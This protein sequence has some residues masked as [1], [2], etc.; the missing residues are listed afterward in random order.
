[1]AAKKDTK[2]T[3]TKKSTGGKKG[4]GILD[5][6][7]DVAGELL[8]SA[9]QGAA[10]TGLNIAAEAVSDMLEGGDAGTKGTSSAGKATKTKAASGGSSTKGSGSAGKTSAKKPGG[11]AGTKGT[12]SAGKTPK[13]TAKTAAKPSGKPP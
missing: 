3:K 4:S 13:S 10:A 7:K 5:K 6:L 1:M 8:S 12:G 9:A 11:D 2:D